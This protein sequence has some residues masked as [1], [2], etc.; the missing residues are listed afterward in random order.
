MP[1]RLTAVKINITRGCR[2]TIHV[3][4]PSSA[5]RHETSLLLES[6]HAL[7]VLVR[8]ALSDL[9]AAS[10]GNVAPEWMRPLFLDRTACCL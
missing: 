1:A 2:T 5:E 9:S 10:Q 7:R 3:A 6:V 4:E 8:G